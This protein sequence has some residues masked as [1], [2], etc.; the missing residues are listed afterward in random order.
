M[1]AKAGLG[2]RLRKPGPK[3]LKIIEPNTLAGALCHVVILLSYLVA[4]LSYIIAL[5]G[6]E[7]SCSLLKIAKSRGRFFEKLAIL[8]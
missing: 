6:V 8:E 5:L 2:F 4:L 1:R 3:K 7:S